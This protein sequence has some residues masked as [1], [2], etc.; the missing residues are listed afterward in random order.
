MTKDLLYVEVMQMTQDVTS[1]INKATKLENKLH[2]R[3]LE[4]MKDNDLTPLQLLSLGE[5]MVKLDKAIQ[6]LEDA[7]Y[8]KCN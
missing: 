1:I 8:V 5:Q 3:F 7:F 4:L 2:T 6:E